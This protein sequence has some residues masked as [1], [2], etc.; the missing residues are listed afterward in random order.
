[1]ISRTPQLYG[2]KP[3]T[4][5]PKRPKPPCPCGSPQYAKGRCRRCYDLAVAHGEI[6][7]D[8]SYRPKREYVDDSHLDVPEPFVRP[9]L[10]MA[11]IFA[12]NGPT[13]ESRDA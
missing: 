7:T 8:S 3:R 5:R 6:V 11:D 2:A 1:M 10:S 9:R 4:K 13:W 12:S